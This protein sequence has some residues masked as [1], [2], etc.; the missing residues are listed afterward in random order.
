MHQYSSV[1]LLSMLG[2]LGLGMLLEL[3][4]LVCGGLNINQVRKLVLSCCSS[5]R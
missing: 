3:G 2:F 5:D 4:F 1:L